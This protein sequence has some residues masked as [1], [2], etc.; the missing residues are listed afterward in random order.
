VEP[1]E[2]QALKNHEWTRIHTNAGGA[3]PTN[4]RLPGDHPRG[5]CSRPDIRAGFDSCSFV[6]IRG[7]TDGLFLRVLHFFAAKGFVAWADRSESGPYRRCCAT[8]EGA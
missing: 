4:L 7:S 2:D 6:S 3:D 1:E 5:R 8:G